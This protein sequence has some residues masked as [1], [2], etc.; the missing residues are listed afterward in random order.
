GMQPEAPVVLGD[1]EPAAEQRRAFAHPDDAVAGTTVPL[2]RCRVD[3]RDRRAVRTEIDGERRRSRAVP[4]GVGERFLHDAMRGPRDAARDAGAF[5][6]HGGGDIEPAGTVALDQ[7]L[8][9]VRV[10][11]YGRRTRLGAERADEPV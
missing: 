10:R 4:R 5:A 3:D 2:A 1:V 6:L 11:R 9:R 7:V 8:E